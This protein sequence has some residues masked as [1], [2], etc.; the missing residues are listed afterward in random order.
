MNVPL[1]DLF[2]AVC[3]TNLAFRANG[4]AMTCSLA[5]TPLHAWHAAHGGRLVDFAG[6]SMPVQYTSITEEHLATRQHVTLFDVSHMGRLRFD[7]ADVSR[8]LDGLLTRQVADLAPGRI[9][10]S[11]VTQ[12]DGGILDDVL[13]YH[14]Q[15]PDGQSF[16]WMVV[17][18]SNREKIVKWIDAQ[19]SSELDVTYTDHTTQTA[20]IAVQGPQAMN[21]AQQII[22][23][24]D[25]AAMRYYRGQIV[26]RPNQNHWLV[27]RTGYTGENGVELVVPADEA[28]DVWEQLMS[29]GQS[30]SIAAAG[31]GARDTL[32]LEAAMPLYG[33]EL[34]EEINP[35]QA[36]LGFAVDVENRNFPG[37]D[38]IQNA[39]VDANLPRRV[40]LKLSGKRVPRQHYAT[41]NAAGN[42]IGEIT[43]GTYSPTLDCPIAMA[44]VAP[45]HS[46]P[47]EHVSVDIRGR[48]EPAAVVPLPFY[49]RS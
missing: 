1:P 19:I 38:A 7:G 46:Q 22:S 41:L 2:L 34:S 20:M 47:G 39:L 12:D 5:E 43:S 17:N 29:L 23:D 3:G 14:L 9:R 24:V 35:I 37:R 36:G 21:V 18:A 32:R 4:I 10:Y 25:L 45:A 26:G 30:E 6:W 16:H 44:Y 27:S 28:V 13:V 49:Q 40:G 15:D 42:T 11:L 8:F 48:T 33:H 31:L